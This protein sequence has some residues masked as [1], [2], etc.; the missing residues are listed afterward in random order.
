M[1]L[2]SISA[3]WCPACLI[4][5]PRIEKVLNNFKDVELVYY[6]YDM[7]EEIVETYQIGTTLP[8]F[9]LLDGNHEITRIV[10]EKSEAEILTVLKEYIK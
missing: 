8:V 6:D 1:K 7:D 4:M 10:G 2:I 5:R 9:I 3:L